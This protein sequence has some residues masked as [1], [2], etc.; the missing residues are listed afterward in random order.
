MCGIAG[1]VNWNNFEDE[2]SIKNMCDAIAHRVFF[3]IPAYA[4]CQW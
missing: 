1:I 2:S 3:S 4:R